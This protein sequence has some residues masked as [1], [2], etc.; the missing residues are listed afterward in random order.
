MT[1]YFRDR[2]EDLMRVEDI[3][4]M[5]RDIIKAA[6]TNNGEL[7]DAG[8]DTAVSKVTSNVNRG[9]ADHEKKKPLKT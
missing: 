8:L 2:T 4:L 3:E 6:Y 7:D 1:Q 5:V 9:P